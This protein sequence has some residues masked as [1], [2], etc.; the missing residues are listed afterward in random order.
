M[1]PPLTVSSAHTKH[2]LEALHPNIAVFRHP[3]HLPDAKVFQSSFVSSLQ[4]L[5]LNA[6]TA[7]KLPGNALQAIYGMNEDVILYWAHH[8]KLCLVDGKIAF[9]GG[10]DLC[11]GRWDTNQHPIADAHPGDLQRIVYPGQDYNNARVMDFVAVDH[12][13]DNKLDRSKASRMGWSDVSFCLSGPVV[14]DLKEHFADRWNFIYNEKYDVRSDSRYS[15][16]SIAH[17]DIG[18]IPH[19]AGGIPAEDHVFAPLNEISNT[20]VQ[21]RGDPTSA[22]QTQPAYEPP[23]VRSAE[24]NNVLAPDVS[25][26]HAGQSPHGLSEVGR[27]RSFG[28][29][30]LRAALK[31]K[32]IWGMEH[33]QE[34]MRIHQGELQPPQGYQGSMAC[35]IVR[36]CTKWSNGSPTEASLISHIVCEVVRSNSRPR[37]TEKWPLRQSSSKALRG[38]LLLAKARIQLN[39]QPQSRPAISHSV[40]RKLAGKPD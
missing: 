35:Q 21:S 9:M 38:L 17:S 33:V 24:G 6:A 10:L 16:I 1:E 11:F 40:Y 3:D 15:R 18:S 4:K 2:A 22:S 31:E 5:S 23:S 20:A 8:E 36:S 29:G 14:N 34:E 28:H 19:Q 32:A 25:T 26:A 27:G 7:S 39:M 12:P 30:G 37:F 13:D